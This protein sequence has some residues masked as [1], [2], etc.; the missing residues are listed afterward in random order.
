MCIYVCLMS[1]LDIARA[2]ERAEGPWGI[3]V[4]KN[5]QCKN[6]QL[7]N[8]LYSMVA[9]LTVNT[10]LIKTMQRKRKIKKQREDTAY[11]GKNHEIET[12]WG[13]P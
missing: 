4:C 3:A 2:A 7:I 11:K 1:T 9:T 12:S 8:Y 5:F 13:P 10:L 6:F